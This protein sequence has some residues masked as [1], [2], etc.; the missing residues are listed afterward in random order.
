TQPLTPLNGAKIQ[1]QLWKN[2]VQT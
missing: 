2:K 1:W